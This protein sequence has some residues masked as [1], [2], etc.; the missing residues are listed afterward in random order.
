ME[1][2]SIAIYRI[3][4]FQNKNELD[5]NYPIDIFG[6]SFFD[7]LYDLFRE[8][9]LSREHRVN[10]DKKLTYKIKDVSE[11]NG[12]IYGKFSYGNYGYKRIQYEI[13]EKKE[14][15]VSHTTSSEIDYFFT[16]GK[17]KFNNISSIFLL[18]QMHGPS[19]IKSF[20]DTTYV[21]MINDSFKRRRSSN[22]DAEKYKINILSFNYGD[23]KKIINKGIVKNIRLYKDRAN[24]DRVIELSKKFKCTNLKARE[25]MVI[26]GLKYKFGNFLDEFYEMEL[27][28]DYDEDIKIDVVIN[29]K[30]T[31]IVVDNHKKISTR[32]TRIDI[33]NKLDEPEN[34][35]YNYENLK[36]VFTEE[37]ASI[38]QMLEGE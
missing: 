15:E 37:F 27:H 4:L 9:E 35:E 12:M 1:N 29:G 32:Q 6:K 3:E 8:E 38:K 26:T 13:K 21:K 28:T 25:E 10:E 17:A 14:E 31:V 30:P 5:A 11:E 23:Y 20:I 24:D 33:S 34:G 2:T 16:L 19:G 18:L 7:F 36:K 22:I